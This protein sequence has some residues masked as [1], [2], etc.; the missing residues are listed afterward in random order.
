MCEGGR[1]KPITEQQNQLLLG[2]GVK[3]W[4]QLNSYA[5]KRVCASMMIIKVECHRQGR[6][7]RISKNN[8]TKAKG[9][10]IIMDHHMS[11]RR[12]D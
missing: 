12:I 4:F 11:R 9:I 6:N 5:N 7:F 2:N 1:G 3:R 8:Q 10:I